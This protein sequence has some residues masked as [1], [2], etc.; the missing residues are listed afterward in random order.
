MEDENKSSGN[1][2]SFLERMKQRSQAQKKY[3]DDIFQPKDTAE[4][5]TQDCPNCGAGRAKRDIVVMSL[6]KRPWMMVSTSQKRITLG[7]P[8]NKNSE[9]IS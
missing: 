9:T 3:G 1:T 4:I 5:D 6:Y 7:N 2:M 8:I